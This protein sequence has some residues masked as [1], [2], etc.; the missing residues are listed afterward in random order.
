[1]TGG[2]YQGLQYYYNGTAWIEGQEKTAIN[3]SPLF[4]V[5]DTTGVS[6]STYT[7]STFVGTQIFSYGVG[8]GVND[9]VLGFPF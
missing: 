8:T 4:D 2:P 7:D 9:A 5:F 6:I 1:M 3:Q